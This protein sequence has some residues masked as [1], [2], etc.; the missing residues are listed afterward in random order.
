MFQRRSRADLAG[1]M[2][3]ISGF[4]PVANIWVPTSL[5]LAERCWR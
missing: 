3:T 4:K 1:S 2:K 5:L